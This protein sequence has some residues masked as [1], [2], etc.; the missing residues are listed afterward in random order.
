MS[1]RLI[2]GVNTD[3]HPDQAR[4]IKKAMQAALGVRVF[5]VSNC[6]ALLLLEDGEEVDG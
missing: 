2:V 4:E 5:V 3:L 1:G 6:S